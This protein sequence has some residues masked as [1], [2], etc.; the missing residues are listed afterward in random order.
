MWEAYTFLQFKNNLYLY[1][2]VA[3]TLHHRDVIW[4]FYSTQRAKS[5]GLIINLILL[6]HYLLDNIYGVKLSN[7]LLGLFSNKELKKLVCHYLRA[8]NLAYQTFY[9]ANKDAL[10]Q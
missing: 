5:P 8:Y 10:G 2:S 6:G 3:Y 4:I 7:E 1:R 9:M